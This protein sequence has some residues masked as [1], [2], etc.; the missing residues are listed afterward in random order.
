MATT[1]ILPFATA[2]GADVVSQ[3]TYA[4]SSSTATGFVNGIA[5]PNMVN[6]VWR[7]A[8]FIA[9]GIANALV[10]LDINVPDDGVLAT[11]VTNLN[12]AIGGLN[13]I[14]I[15]TI[16]TSV[17]LT[18]LET[19]KTP[20]F[21]IGSPAGNF[22]I[23]IPTVSFNKSV[24]NKTG[25]VATFG[26]AAGTTVTLDDGETGV[27]AGDGTNVV[28][29]SSSRMAVAA[30]LTGGTSGSPTLLI[31]GFN[32]ALVDNSTNEYLLPT[33]RAGDRVT[34][35]ND[36]SPAGGYI[37]QAPG[38]GNIN[39]ASSVSVLSNYTLSVV[40]STPGTWIVDYYSPGV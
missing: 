19:Y 20:W 35:K 27:I 16:T 14:L 10:N 13:T 39:G 9:S 30:G 2:G 28:R 1:E 6:K 18:A 29:I 34:L 31:V 33:G 25:K 21:F 5:F 32:Q 23:T 38:G 15:K 3:A 7:Q 26:Y 36:I 37:M 11:L 4:A 12:R 40:C 24:S 17:T 22:T 8:S